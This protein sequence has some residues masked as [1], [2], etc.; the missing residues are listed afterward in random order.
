MRD[1]GG[2]FRLWRIF[3]FIYVYLGGVQFIDLNTKKQT[4]KDV[5]R[6][7]KDVLRVKKDVLRVKKTLQK[8]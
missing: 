3:M 7:K 4:K 5:L 6:V 2:D 8:V 1:F